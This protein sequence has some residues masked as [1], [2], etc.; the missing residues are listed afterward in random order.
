MAYMKKGT[1]GWYSASQ[2]FMLQ[3]YDKR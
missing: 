3:Q 1:L 2:G